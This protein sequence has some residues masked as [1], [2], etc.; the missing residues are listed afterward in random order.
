MRR[1][2]KPLARSP[3]VR[4]RT[5][6]ASAR[7]KF[8]RR[9]AIESLEPRRLLAAVSVVGSELVITDLS[10]STNDAVTVLADS[11][12][13]RYEIS[14]PNNAI[15][16]DIPSATGSGTNTLLV[17]FAGLT[18]NS[19]LITLVGG[20]DTATL[21]GDFPVDVT[22]GGDAGLDTISLTLDATFAAD[23]SL[24]V[25]ADTIN[26]GADVDVV[27]SG[28]GEISLAADNMA[29]DATATISSAATVTLQQQSPGRNVLV[30][31]ESPATA[32]SLTDAELD[33]ISAATTRIIA[34]GSGSLAV[35]GAITH[36]N[37]LSLIQS[38]SGGIS[39]TAPITMAADTN[40]SSAIPNFSS[41]P[42]ATQ[43]LA[44]STL[45]G[46]IITSGSGTIELSSA[47][48]IDLGSL[49]TLSSQNGEIVLTANSI[50]INGT[51]SVASAAS[52]ALQPHSA[53]RQ[54][55][56]GTENPSRLGLTDA[57]LDR[58]T[59]GQVQIG[60]ASS[61]VLTIT[62]AITHGNDLSLIASGGINIAQAIT[63][64]ADK[65]FSATNHGTSTLISVTNLGV[66]V[67][68]IVTSG[69]GAITLDAAWA[70]QI[71]GG[72]TLLT[73]NGG[74]T[75]LANQ[76]GTST[77]SNSMIQI[78]SGVG[79]TVT[80]TGTG[81]ILIDGRGIGAGAGHDAVVV[82]G[83]QSL[84]TTNAPDQGTITIN[85]SDGLAG[86][87]I[88]G[89]I[90][91]NS[92]DITINGQGGNQSGAFT[93][94][95]VL[96]NGGLAASNDASIS[97]TGT[98]GSST[99]GHA[100]GID[101]SFGGVSSQNGAI[102]LSGTG[103]HESTST[104][105][106]ALG[107]SITG[108][109]TSTTGAI[110]LEG[111]GGSSPQVDY[112]VQITALGLTARVGAGGPLSILGTPGAGANSYGVV[113]LAPAGQSTVI[114]GS[115][116]MHVT[117]DS[118]NASINAR[119]ELTG[120]VTYVPL[121][122]GLPISLGGDDMLTGAKR[123]G[124]SNSELFRVHA[125]AVNIGDATSGDISIDG[126]ISPDTNR[127]RSMQL[128]S[129]GDIIF[130]SN[131]S[132][133]ASN[134]APPIAGSLLLSPGPDGSVRPL[135]SPTDVTTETAGAVFAITFT[136]GAD[137]EINIE[138]TTLNT[139]YSQL[140][141][142]GDVDLTGVDL[143]V[144]GSFVS[145]LGD[146]FTFV[147]ATNI[148][149]Q[150]NGLEEDWSIVHNGRALRVNYTPA[151]LTLTDV[152][153]PPTID[154]DAAA[155]STGEGSPVTNTGTF[156]DPDGNATATVTASIGTVTQDND[157]GTWSWSLDTVDGPDGPFEVTITVTDIWSAMDS[158]TFE[159]SVNN[160]PPTVT[161]AGSVTVGE[162]QLAA[163][164]GTWG[165]PGMD[166][167]TLGASIGDIVQNM[168]GTWSWSLATTDGPD[169]SQTVTI[170]ATDSDGAESQ[171]TFQLTVNNVAP[172]VTTLV[173]PPEI[174]RGGTA[175]F[176]GEFEDPAEDSWQGEAEIE[177]AGHEPVVV[178]VVVNSDHTFGFEYPFQD[179]GLY[180][181]TVTI[182][183]GEAGMPASHSAMIFVFI[184]GDY[185]RNGAVEEADYPVW[186]QNFGT[187]SAAGLQ[188]D[189]NGNGSVDAADY[190]VWRKNLGTTG[191]AVVERAAT[192][193]SQSLASDAGAT[194]SAMAESI[195]TPTGHPVI[196]VIAVAAKSIPES[197]STKSQAAART[198]RSARISRFV[199]P[200]DQR[201][202]ARPTT[203]KLARVMLPM[204]AIIDD[205]ILL[206]I[207][208]Q[209]LK[210]QP[211][212]LSEI[213]S[214]TLD[215]PPVN[216]QLPEVRDLA[217][218]GLDVRQAW[219]RG[220]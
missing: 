85:G 170:T 116:S 196:D 194:K 117:T 145:S 160:L 6:Q 187:T 111:T 9:L 142:V 105:D 172:S 55:H 113:V 89:A 20:D 1:F 19:V 215:T 126:A 22:L 203:S 4:P 182:V 207:A 140:T 8:S 148:T 163:N 219:T 21:G 35:G 125:S 46:D 199:L 127:S 152:G 119:I 24:T 45:F 5:S 82:S 141:A 59:A 153:Q 25:S 166:D 12:N 180:D 10:G 102:Y 101:M 90:T 150:F 185:D 23:A 209:R 131:L 40:F 169:E 54:I 208:N 78:V 36:A 188:A 42:G 26:L 129:G 95:G 206:E 136:S 100:H 58:I 56:V 73:E 80:S 178:P 158:V 72:G 65:N 84:S 77:T 220:R 214:A 118:Y 114:S 28:A 69:T 103:G 149:G 64:D 190:V 218:A 151:T 128:I 106:G 32:L 168:D 138:G 134:P 147:S 52:V 47:R 167:V 2:Y 16:T 27:T 68:H 174:V 165:D 205:R 99:G 213:S 96:F 3:R 44:L 13:E 154:V 7:R 183:D 122:E 30:G 71:N 130:N 164:T 193:A 70:I 210:A 177:R 17:P 62:S 135:A 50:E 202:P 179:A 212:R 60:N 175:A 66:N 176:T 61:G 197:K 204:P 93:V 181:V 132:T 34:N 144:T 123:V 63:M 31:V 191:S 81:N 217:F 97:I 39:I 14:D 159:Y 41:S 146:V 120:T 48:T 162:G 29:I 157:L 49:A 186:R 109:V 67:G 107:I 86:V 91:S 110:H 173:G 161:S 75:L 195:A 137:L 37:H 74:I 88:Q 83:I 216:S 124:I 18:A 51:A 139:Q 79:S 112:G 11:V 87:R 143:V 211:E 189:G 33:R 156:N 57:E 94:H 98:G 200:D 53:G 108:V 201:L 43:V 192:A 38:D 171:T 198:H 155:V 76:A 184:P 104:G 133:I 92:G 15:L 121:T 115:S